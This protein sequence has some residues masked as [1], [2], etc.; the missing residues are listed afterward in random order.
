MEIEFATTEV[1]SLK[2]RVI[3]CN[4]LDHPGF[5]KEKISIKPCITCSLSSAQLS[6]ALMAIYSGLH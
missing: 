6:L 2:G 3:S 4:Y 5:A 1:E